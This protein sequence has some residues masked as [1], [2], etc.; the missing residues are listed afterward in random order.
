MYRLAVYFKTPPE[1]RMNLEE[2]Y[3]LELVTHSRRGKAIAEIKPRKA[4]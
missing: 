2:S 1:Y 3:D 4:G